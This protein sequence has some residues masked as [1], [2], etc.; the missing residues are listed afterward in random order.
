M[1][2][3][4]LAVR[5]L[6]GLGL[7]QRDDLR[8]GQHRYECK[9]VSDGLRRFQDEEL[10]LRCCAV[11]S[12]LVVVS[13]PRLAFS[14]RRGPSTGAD[15]GGHP[16]VHSSGQPPPLNDSGSRVSFRAPG[17]SLL[18]T[19]SIKAKP[20]KAM[21]SSLHTSSSLTQSS[22]QDLNDPILLGRR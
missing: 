13:T 14:P 18:L 9:I 2:A 22:V 12:L 8:L 5:L 16:C 15:H 4:E 6:L 21:G 10:C 11:R 3:L 20:E 17:T 1:L 19:A 7:F